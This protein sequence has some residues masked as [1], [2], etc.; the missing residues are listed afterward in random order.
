V[1]K[2]FCGKNIFHQRKIGKN[3][4]APDAN[5]KLLKTSISII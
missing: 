5:K 2:V 4:F 3:D 1:R